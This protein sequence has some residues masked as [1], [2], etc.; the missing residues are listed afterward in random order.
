MKKLIF[1]AFLLITASFGFAKEL[2]GKN[3]EAVYMALDARLYVNDYEELQDQLAYM[4]RVENQIKNIE[5]EISDEAKLIYKTVI[6]FQKATLIATDEEKKAEKQ[7]KKDIKKDEETEK[8][9]MD[10]YNR[11]I[12]FEATHENLS[13][14]FYFHFNEAKMATIPYLTKAKQLELLTGL[15]DS[16]KFVEELNPNNSEN[17]FTLAAI[18]YA[19]PKIAGGNKEEAIEK[20]EKAIN[21]A[22]CNYEKSSAIILYSQL[23]FEDNQI[24]KS[25]KL[26]DE[27]LKL[28]PEN[29]PMI[30]Y[31]EMNEAGFSMFKEKE[32]QKFVEKNN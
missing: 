21:T 22:G 26:F 30:H 2:E 1:V 9:V 7:K 15:L 17:L 19:M 27:G 29:K 14:Y 23:L 24:E 13:S 31:K 16:Y 3:L 11:Y 8:K 12:E 4:N 32:Y 10:T 28:D 18:L 6:E 25:K 5:S 20:I